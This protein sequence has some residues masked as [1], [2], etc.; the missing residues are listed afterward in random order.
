MKFALVGAIVVILVA[1]LLIPV[2]D[3]F[4]IG[5]YPITDLSQPIPSGTVIEYDLNWT[6]LAPSGW[7]DMTIS[8]DN[9]GYNGHQEYMYQ[10]DQEGNCLPGAVACIANQI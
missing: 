5:I 10:F 2:D 4:G 7:Y 3:A 9:N 8:I 1:V 6:S